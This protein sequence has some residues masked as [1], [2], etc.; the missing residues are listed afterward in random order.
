M[1]KRIFNALGL[2]K[3]TM[4]FRTKDYSISFNC[5][6][7]LNTYRKLIQTREFDNTAMTLQIVFY[8]GKKDS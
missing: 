1:I 3:I 2:Y 4:H 5:V 8:D 7:T 6:V